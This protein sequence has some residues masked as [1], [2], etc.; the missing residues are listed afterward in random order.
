MTD[1]DFEENIE[2]EWDNTVWE[3]IYALVE[4]LL[5][6]EA[7]NEKKSLEEIVSEYLQ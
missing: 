7:E 5:E 3:F 1:I 4:T 6:M 2:S